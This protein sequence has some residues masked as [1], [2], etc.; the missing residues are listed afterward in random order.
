MYGPDG[1]DGDVDSDVDGNEGDG[2][3]DDNNDNDGDNSGDGAGGNDGDRSD[4]NDDGGYGDCHVDHDSDDDADE[5]N[6]EDNHGGDD[7][8]HYVGGGVYD[9][10]DD[11]DGCDDD[12]DGN[13]DDESINEFHWNL[14]VT[15]SS[16]VMPIGRKMLQLDKFLERYR[17]KTLL[18]ALIS[19]S[20]ILFLYQGLIG[21]HKSSPYFECKNIKGTLPFLSTDFTFTSLSPTFGQRRHVIKTNRG[22]VFAM[23]R[24]FRPKS[25]PT[26]KG[27]QGPYVKLNSSLERFQYSET[28]ECLDRRREDCQTKT[29]RIRSKALEQKYIDNMVIRDNMNFQS[30]L[31]AISTTMSPSDLTPSRLLVTPLITLPSAFKI[32]KSS[33]SAP[34]ATTSGPLTSP[35]ST[36]QRPSSSSLLTTSGS[37]TSSSSSSS[38]TTQ[39]V[40]SSVLSLSSTASSFSSPT[41]SLKSFST[42][43]SSKSSYRFLLASPFIGLYTPLSLLPS[44]SLPKLFPSSMVSQSSK[45]PLTFS[46]FLS[47]SSVYRPLSKSSAI[48]TFKTKVNATDKD[49]KPMVL[50]HSSQYSPF[51]YNSS[52]GLITRPAALYSQILNA[53]GASNLTPRFKPMR[54]R[55]QQRKQR[56][57]H[58]VPYEFSKTLNE[59]VEYRYGLSTVNNLKHKDEMQSHLLSTLSSKFKEKRNANLGDLNI[60]DNKTGHNVENEGGTKL[61]QLLSRKLV[62][63][64]NQNTILIIQPESGTIKKTNDH[65]N[66]K[67]EQVPQSDQSVEKKAKTIESLDQSTRESV[68]VSSSWCKAIYDE[69]VISRLLQIDCRGVQFRD[70]ASSIRLKIP[71]VE[72]L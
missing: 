10:E 32:P 68:G 44:L 62:S 33:S 4:D 63:N 55:F 20:A 48:P 8:D 37:L 13:D 40:L 60:Y 31:P 39:T 43:I 22:K 7:Y 65:L 34:P 17:L 26:D 35:S 71:S 52:R 59:R 54:S 29:R 42:P 27:L 57:L 5:D 30:L 47:S 36:T 9:D 49:S 53:Q 58:S 1:D 70:V 69:H 11:R 66:K 23:K 61:L 67:S 51:S 50:T 38:S 2:G 3:S 19:L 28:V 6:N 72:K 64:Y 25:L 41:S 15:N 56:S 16:S 21:V 45:S 18:M 24:A 12:D 46:E 14:Q